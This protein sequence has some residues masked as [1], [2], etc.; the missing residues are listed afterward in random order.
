MAILGLLSAILLAAVQA[1]RESGRQTTCR[2][3]LHDLG[4]A[5][6]AYE[7]ANSQFPVGHSVGDFSFHVLLLPY[8]EQSAL[9]QQIRAATS[10]ASKDFSYFYTPPAGLLCPSDGGP[11]ENDGFGA[12]CSYHGNYGSGQQ[13]YGYNGMFS[14]LVVTRGMVTDGLSHTAAVSEVLVGNGSSD[15]LRQICKTTEE[16]LGP[17][18]LDLFADRCLDPYFRIPLDEPWD[19]GRP[20][21]DGNVRNTLY[22][23]VI[24]PNNVACGNGSA[25]QEGAYPPTSNHPAF[26]HVLFAD[27]HCD[28]ISASISRLPWRQMGSRDGG[29]NGT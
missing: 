2:A 7:A 28:P 15:P 21:T 27:G 20:W 12:G 19:R 26:V 3:Q 16:L 11:W 6:S 17:D 4:I 10:G 5:I 29:M 13:K 18:Q 1:A 9:E 22:N 25:V 14:Y 23:H 24:T 8:R